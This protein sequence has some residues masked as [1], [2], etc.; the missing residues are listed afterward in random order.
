[1]RFDPKVYL[2]NDVMIAFLCDWHFFYQY[3]TVQI[4]S[5]EWQRSTRAVSV[6]RK[7]PQKNSTQYT[8]HGSR[9]P[10]PPAWNSMSL[11]SALRKGT[12]AWSHVG[13]HHSSPSILRALRPQTVFKSFQTGERTWCFPYKL[14]YTIDIFN[15][16]LCLP[17]KYIAFFFLIKCLFY[18]YALKNSS[19]L[20]AKIIFGCEI[21][22][23]RNR[24]ESYF[25][26]IV[27]V[28]IKIL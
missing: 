7:R 15:C 1:M 8:V 24:Y 14:G 6:I 9:A 25:K 19:D 21:N 27:K 17:R 4:Q 5:E 12:N 26:F 13:S 22:N 28:W 3:L 18:L 2:N 10:P 20:W 16:Q 11:F 23:L